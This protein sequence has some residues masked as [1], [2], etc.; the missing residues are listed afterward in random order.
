M[1]VVDDRDQHLA[2]MVQA[3]GLLYYQ[4]AFATEVHAIRVDLESLA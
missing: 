4:P 3:L 2:E 1:R